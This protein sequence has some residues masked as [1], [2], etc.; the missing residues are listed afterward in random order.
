VGLYYASQNY[1]PLTVPSLSDY[2]IAVKSVIKGAFLIENPVLS[3]LLIP[4]FLFFIPIWRFYQDRSFDQSTVAIALALWV[5]LVLTGI[6]FLLA[7]KKGFYVSGRHY[8]FLTPLV[9]LVF[10][11]SLYWMACQYRP[12]LKG[13]VPVLVLLCLTGIRIDLKI[14]AAIRILKGVAQDQ[15]PMS[16]E[17]CLRGAVSETK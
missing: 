3:Y 2:L 6:L 14:P 17:A 8:I 16:S 7:A 9:Y 11:Q 12:A 4:V 15:T 1:V 5:Q 13:L 10:C